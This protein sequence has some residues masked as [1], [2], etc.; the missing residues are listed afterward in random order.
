MEKIGSRLC[1]T[2]AIPGNDR[3]LV[4]KNPAKLGIFVW[5]EPGPL[6]EWSSEAGD[7]H[8][9]RARPT[10]EDIRGKAV[11]ESR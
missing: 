9:K 7:F 1:F 5:Q 3:W 4:G 6:S 8:S 10:H 11:A 2:F